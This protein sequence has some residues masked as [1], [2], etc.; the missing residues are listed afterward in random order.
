M[1]VRFAGIR[2]RAAH[3]AEDGHVADAE[4]DW[5]GDGLQNEADR[6]R[7]KRSTKELGAA[8]MSEIRGD[9]LCY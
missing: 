8:A 5:V 3:C 7:Q 6:R 2:T 4:L 1:P 9:W